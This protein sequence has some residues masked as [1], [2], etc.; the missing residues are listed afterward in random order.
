VKREFVPLD[1]NRVRSIR[2][3]TPEAAASRLTMELTATPG[4]SGRVW[5]NDLRLQGQR[6]ALEAY[7]A[8]HLR[9]PRD[10]APRR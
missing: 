4:V 6:P 10:A 2:I 7:V 1:S 9:F 8:S 3:D 5:I